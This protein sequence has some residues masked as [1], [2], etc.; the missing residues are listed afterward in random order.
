MPWLYSGVT[1]TKASEAATTA[2]HRFGVLV[3]LALQPRVVGL[4]EQLQGE[5]GQVG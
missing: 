3:L 1:N 5:L 2:L 4:V